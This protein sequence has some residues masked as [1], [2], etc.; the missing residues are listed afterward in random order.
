MSSRSTLET[1]PAADGILARAKGTCSIANQCAG[2]RQLS[3]AEAL[4]NNVHC[5]CQLG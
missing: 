1:L 2:L 5:C 4:S 3:A